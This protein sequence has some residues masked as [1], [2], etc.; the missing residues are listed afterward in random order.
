MLKVYLKV[1]VLLVVFN[2]LGAKASCNEEFIN[3]QNIQADL[4]FIED[5][6]LNDCYAELRSCET[7]SEL[8]FEQDM[9][10]GVEDSIDP[11]TEYF[12]DE[13]EVAYEN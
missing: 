3:C 9:T 2:T 6:P 12:E 8:A 13:T 5:S 11:L 7:E 4:E 10:E 1:M